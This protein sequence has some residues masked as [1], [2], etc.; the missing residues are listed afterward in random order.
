MQQKDSTTHTQLPQQQILANKVLSDY[1]NPLQQI[2][3]LTIKNAY[4]EKLIARQLDSW[5]ERTTGIG[6]E[7]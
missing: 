6:R 3:Q 5:P 7:K 1:P 4:S 2:F